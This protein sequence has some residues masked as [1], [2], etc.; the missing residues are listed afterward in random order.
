MLTIRAG[1]LLAGAFLGLVLASPC[2]AQPKYLTDTP[3]AWK[4]WKP[5]TAIAS[6]RADQ[7]VTPAQVKAFE[8]S[9]LEL[10]AILKRAP[11]VSPPVGFSVETWGHLSEYRVREVAPGQPRGG[12]RPMSGAL[13]FGAF[14]I[15]EY[16]RNGKTIREDSGETAILQFAINETGR[17]LIDSGGGVD[18]WSGL[19]HDAFLKPLP[20]GEIAGLPRYGDGL[21]VARDPEALWA[22]LSLAD[23]L[24]L[25]VLNRRATVDG[26]KESVRKFN[27][28]LAKVRDPARRAERLKSAKE[29][30]AT[31]RDGAAFVAQ[32]EQSLKIE[33]E[34]LL[35][36]IGP[37]GAT[38]R[39]L[40][41]AEKAL[42][43]V[44]SWLGELSPEE[45]AAPACYAKAAKTVRTKF[46][47]SPSASC[48]PLVRP[49]YAYFDK[50]LPRSAP[51]VLIITP[52]TRCW[53]TAD[54]Y[55]QEANSP[56]PSGCRANRRL[57]ETVD[58]DALRAWVQSPTT[59]PGR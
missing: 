2:H 49:N 25:V 16:V 28:Q 55:N 59:S 11:S 43:D 54:R 58:K 38:A 8:A 36:E 32:V 42:G 51:Q 23:A 33:E 26:Y 44:T 48:V 15:F 52:I 45:K 56:L 50:S 7:A 46:R 6:A 30:A 14:P 29:A 39:G 10:N 19:D 17:G 37:A 4:P 53:D 57:V 5:L 31:M 9:L 20:K 12:G 40:A 22:P 1:R 47:T 18:E 35:R 27:E 41:E 34:S 13:S 21:V 3:G 24:N